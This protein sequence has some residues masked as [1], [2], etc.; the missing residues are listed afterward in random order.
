MT[1]PWATPGS[2]TTGTP[3]ESL[4][5]LTSHVGGPLVVPSVT[6]TPMTGVAT[7]KSTATPSGTALP[8]ASVTTA[9]TTV[10]SVPSPLFCAPFVT[11]DRVTST[12]TPGVATGVGV[13]GK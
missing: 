10:V 6:T 1:H 13:P 9:A 2:S 8:Y 4:K 12:G 7:E 3:V 11:R 5:L